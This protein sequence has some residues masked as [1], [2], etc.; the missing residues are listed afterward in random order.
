[1]ESSPRLVNLNVVIGTD[2]EMIDRAMSEGSIRMPSTDF[3]NALDHPPATNC[4][5]QWIV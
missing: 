1:M 2:N 5:N 4:S 3:V